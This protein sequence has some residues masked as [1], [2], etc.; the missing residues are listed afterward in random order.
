VVAK[1]RRGFARLALETGASLVPVIGVGEP[2]VCS[3]P[4]LGARVLK[5]L[6]A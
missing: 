5:L 1:C 3:K 6:S 2:F 4:A